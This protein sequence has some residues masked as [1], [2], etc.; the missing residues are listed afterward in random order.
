M[1][2]ALY[3]ALVLDDLKPEKF[4]LLSRDIATIDAHGYVNQTSAPQGVG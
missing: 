1:E 4:Q 3:H 2:K